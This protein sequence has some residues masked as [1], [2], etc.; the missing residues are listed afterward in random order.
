MSL[1]TASDQQLHQNS[2]TWGI[3]LH[4]HKNSAMSRLVKQILSNATSIH[5]QSHLTSWIYKLHSPIRSHEGLHI[6]WRRNFSMPASYR[7]LLPFLKSQNKESQMS[8]RIA[9]HKG[10]WTKFQH[11]KTCRK[12]GYR[13]YAEYSSKNWYIYTFSSSGNKGYLQWRKSIC[14]YK[15]YSRLNTLKFYWTITFMK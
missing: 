1:S 3:N 2:W 7:H 14:F 4:E 13:P 10:P 15:M 6:F 12:L 8:K 9:R 5:N 11:S